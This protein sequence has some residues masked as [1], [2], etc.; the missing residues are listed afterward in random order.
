MI[1]FLFQCVQIFLGWTPISSVPNEE[2]VIIYNHTSYWDGLIL[3]LYHREA[4][5]IAVAKP[6]IFTWYTKRILYNFGVV[7]TSRLEDRG[8]N[9]VNKLVE[10]V[11][12]TKSIPKRPKMLVLSPKGTVYQAEWRS[13]Y[14]ALATQ[15]K[16]PIKL[17]LIDYN[18][19]TIKIVDCDQSEAALM[20]GL[21]Y[22]VPKN[23]ENSELRIH[24][25]YDAFELLTFC[26]I[27]LLSN[28][29]MI[30]AIWS[31]RAYPGLCLL[32]SC[33]FLV[34][35]IYHAS[36]ETIL[37]KCDALLSKT[38]ILTCSLYFIKN[39]DSMVLTP[40]AFSSVFY[41]AGTPRLGTRGTYIIWHTLFHI[42][43][44]YTAWALVNGGGG[45]RL[46]A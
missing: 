34:S 2:C 7:P 6:Q 14:R 31:L 9:A 3:F 40:L 12:L 45:G 30:P 28:L 35:C 24:K 13:G 10:I 33:T 38:L 17:G 43:I 22:A 39:F 21:G 11:H 46:R 18:E 4:N 23:P 44:S 37:C 5:F 8:Q 25:T 36:R 15:L 29:A 19:R 1:R 26:D 20:H 16:W 41:W 42:S 27:V 32:A